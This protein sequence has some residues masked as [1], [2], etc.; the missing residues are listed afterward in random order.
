[1][2]NDSDV[3]ISQGSVRITE[4]INYHS[5]S[6][7][8]KVKN[9][10]RTIWS[11]EFLNGHGE[12]D[13]VLAMQKKMFSTDI[14]FDPSAEFKF[15]QGCGIITVEYKI[16]SEAHVNGCHTNLENGTQITIGTVPFGAYNQQLPPMM[17]HVPLAPLT[18]MPNA[19]ALPYPSA[20]SA[21]LASAP[22]GPVREQPLPSYNDAVYKPSM[23]STSGGIGWA[24]AN[25][26]EETRKVKH[27]G[28]DFINF[29]TFSSPN[30]PRDF[31]IQRKGENVTTLRRL[32]LV[33]DNFAYN[34]RE[35]LF[36]FPEFH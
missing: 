6:P 22:P 13:L 11:H 4:S 32:L 5:R 9:R 1:M 23:P 29:Y 25:P 19:P 17:P 31:G 34:C 16:K 35:F 33:F 21:D 7:S 27:F 30:L 3:S 12:K 26:K 2:N 10:K 14:Y 20:P 36:I 28:F 24:V 8:H 15:F 18:L